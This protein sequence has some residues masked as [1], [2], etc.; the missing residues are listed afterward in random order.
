MPNAL[1][2]SRSIPV[3]VK[4][5]VRQRCYFG[6]INCAASIYQYDH[7]EPEF[8]FAEA[9]DPNGIILLC[10]TCHELKKKG[11]LT[12]DFLKAKAEEPAAKSRGTSQINLPYFT[13]IPI[14]VFG[15]GVRFHEV[16]IPFQIDDVQILSFSPPEA[17]S[18]V[19]RVN[20]LLS[21]SNGDTMLRIVDNEWIVQSGVWDFEWIGSRMSIYN[22]EK[23]ESLRLAILAPHQIQVDRLIAKYKDVSINIDD[24]RI[25]INYASIIA[26]PI[27]G[28]P[29][30]LMAISHPQF[31][32]QSAGVLVRCYSE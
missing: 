10:P 2:L 31:E 19:T 1:G 9:H 23:T 27:V 4:R 32:P 30:G 17:G 14:T 22:S 13:G 29:I 15:G 24:T 16:P 5:K 25:T 20:A 8:A 26:C 6:C 7:L 3:D 12:F 11:V 28:F 21:D 18:S